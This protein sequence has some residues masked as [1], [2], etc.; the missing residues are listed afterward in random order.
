MC[1][2]DNWSTEFDLRSG[3]L[4]EQVILSDGDDAAGDLVGTPQAGETV[5]CF[6]V[7]FADC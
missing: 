3:I 4:A 5:N 1:C 2:G 7:S 6:L